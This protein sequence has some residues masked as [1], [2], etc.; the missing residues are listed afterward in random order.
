MEDASIP[1]QKPQTRLE[2]FSMWLHSPQHISLNSM[3]IGVWRGYLM[4]T[5]QS[6]R[7]C[8]R[9]VGEGM[10]VQQ[11]SWHL[12]NISYDYLY[13]IGFIESVSITNFP[14]IEAI[15]FTAVT[16]TTLAGVPQKG[17][18]CRRGNQKH[19]WTALLSF[20]SKNTHFQVSNRLGRLKGNSVCKVAWFAYIFVA[21]FPFF[22][23]DPGKSSG[24]YT[25]NYSLDPHKNL[26]SC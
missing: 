17:H 26:V 21:F 4:G 2:V 6:F 11:L 18:V 9:P 15:F 14:W 7:C 1:L 10:I 12:S 13:P 3:N 19:R 5:T 20:H 16:L 8:S 23:V 24:M 25:Q 22:P